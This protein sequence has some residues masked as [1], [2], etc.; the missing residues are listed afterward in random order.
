MKALI[1]LVILLGAFWVAKRLIATYQGVEKSRNTGEQVSTVPAPAPTSS[2]PGLPPNLEASLS[3]AEK[4]G[5]PGLRD[6]LNNYRS[7][8]R[9]PRLAAIELDYVVL[10]SHQDPAEARRI[11]QDVKDRTP[12]FS[13]IYQRVKALEKTFQ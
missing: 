11:F 9:D 8:A 4:Q 1:A 6:W 2:L 5:A 12:T 10:I 3:A 7:F 13:P